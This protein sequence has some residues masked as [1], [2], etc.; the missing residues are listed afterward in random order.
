[1][2][3]SMTFFLPD[4]F[5]C[6]QHSARQPPTRHPHSVPKSGL[7]GSGC[8]R[9]VRLPQRQD[10]PLPC[11]E[12]FNLPGHEQHL[13][14]ELT[15]N[16]RRGAGGRGGGCLQHLLLEQQRGAPQWYIWQRVECTQT[17]CSHITACGGAMEV[18][19]LTRAVS[20]DRI[21][22]NQE[23]HTCTRECPRRLFFYSS[24]LIVDMQWLFSEGAWVDKTPVPSALNGV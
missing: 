4:S 13:P 18:R 15:W 9:G 1:M 17:A 14:V 19:T 20:E 3:S 6:Q 23:Y 16:Q 2:T 10:L 5:G 11:R 12:H 21:L 7:P 24:R 8:V 22:W